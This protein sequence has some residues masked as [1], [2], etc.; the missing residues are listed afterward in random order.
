MSRRPEFSW[1]HRLIALG[2]GLGSL[3]HM[4]GLVGLLV[5]WQMYSNYPWWRHAAFA[6]VD[7]SIAWLALRRPQRL[8]VPL[9][10]MLGEQLATNGTEAFHTWQSAHRVEWPII[11]T[12]PLIACA[13]VAVYPGYPIRLVRRAA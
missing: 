3:E 12:L 7:A 1:R 13:V 9:L 6:G 10:A 5:G 11:V 2:F 8:L 4:V